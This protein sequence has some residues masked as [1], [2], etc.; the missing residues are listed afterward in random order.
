MFNLMLE[1]VLRFDELSDEDGTSRE[2]TFT[3]SPGVRGGWNFGD[4]QVILGAAVPIT[5]VERRRRNRASA[6]SLLRAAVQ[7]VVPPRA[8]T[9]ESA[10]HAESRMFWF[11]VLGVLS[12]ERLIA[13]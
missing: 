6:L 3:L 8:F 11:C 9:A 1:S 2:T 10:E 5:W 13:V 12:G 4:Q 7:E